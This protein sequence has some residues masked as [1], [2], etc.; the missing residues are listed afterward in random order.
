MRGK[1]K[2]VHETY[3]FRI[4]AR[5]LGALTLEGFCPRCFW[6]DSHI[7]FPPSPF[8]GI[9]SS[10]DGFSKKAVRNYIDRYGKFPEWGADMGNISGYL[11]VKRLKWHD[12]KS[13]SLLTGV[14]DE[15]LSLVDG[16]CIIIDYKTAR[17]TKT[18]D[19]LMPMYEVQL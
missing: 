7:G 14:P 6:V 3:S 4:S 9:F 18:Q 16:K 15:I 13:D 1:G 17:H 12:K 8:P 2:T 5:A 10:I 19:A 11:E